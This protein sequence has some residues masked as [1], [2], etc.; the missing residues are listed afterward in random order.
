MSGQISLNEWFERLGLEDT[1]IGDTIGW[2]LGDN[3]NN[4][5]NVEISSHVTKDNIPC[6]AISYRIQPVPLKWSS[7]R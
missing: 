1:E 4:L 2:E 7:Y 3:P 5:I 6:G